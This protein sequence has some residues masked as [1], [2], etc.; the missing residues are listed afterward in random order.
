M[1]A[2]A[3]PLR[4]WRGLKRLR[5]WL[6]ARPIV[7]VLVLTLLHGAL[8]AVSVP[9][10]QGPDEPTHYEYLRALSAAPD[11]FPAS[12]DGSEAVFREV[13]ESARR[14]RWWE[15]R[16]QPTPAELPAMPADRPLTV[17]AGYLYYRLSQ[18]V[19]WLLAGQPVEAQLFGLR[20]YSV[21]L[22]VVT[23]A[24]TWLIAELIFTRPTDPA[25][26]LLPAAAALVVA[27]QPQ[28]TFISAIY[29]DDNLVPVWVAAMLYALLRGLRDAADWRWLVLASVA[30]S[31]AALTKR[32]GISAVLLV[33]AAG[34]IYAGLWQRAAGRWRRWAGRLMLGGAALAAVAVIWVMASPPLIPDGL[35]ALAR[36][37]PTAL[38]QL[39]SY[40]QNP[41]QL[42]RVDWVQELVF[43]S[44]TFWGAFGY[45]IAPLETGVMEVLRRVMAL[46]AVGAGAAWLWAC[47]RRRAEP[48]VRFQLL[49]LAL[50]AAGLGFNAGLL[51][52]QYLIGPPVYLL[53]GRYLFPFIAAFGVLAAWG[54][55][56]WWPRAWKPAGLLVGAGL[57]VVLD[58]IA[59]GGTLAP[60]FY[61]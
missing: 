25:E 59:L 37:S 6:A 45:F 31:L 57:L 38:V 58:V 10:W 50:L 56:A 9:P 4:L 14:F 21:T 41:A 40:W 11:L 17:R 35:A 55:Q 46:L 39:A 36:V 15:F 54:W 1:M 28:Y 60:Y 49:A 47:W 51:V 61:S 48:E 12:L 26:R 29:N 24:L 52:T 20:L 30:A 32:T 8:Y 3:L 53:V 44:V 23:V 27:F 22:Q 43:F 33:A 19:Y 2:R 18:P 16:R 5:G 7:P 42:T 13:M 34:L